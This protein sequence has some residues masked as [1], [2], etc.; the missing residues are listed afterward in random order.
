MTP[1]WMMTPNLFA[2]LDDGSALLQVVTRNSLGDN[3]EILGA[4]NLPLGPSGSEFGGIEAG[5]P[6]IYLSSD[7]S[8]FAQ[9]AW[10]F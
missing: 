9:F 1:L 6:G 5:L 7:F 10:Y 3:A 4:I 8:L 2:N